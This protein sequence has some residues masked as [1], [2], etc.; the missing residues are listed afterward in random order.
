MQPC[1]EA[2]RREAELQA[3]GLA[4][5]R[6][7]AA[8]GTEHR[9]ARGARAPARGQQHSQNEGEGGREGEPGA[10]HFVA[11]VLHVDGLEKGFQ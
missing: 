5:Q 7:M 4:A 2:V 8:Q 3:P 10:H 6:A 9:S 1:Q 11:L